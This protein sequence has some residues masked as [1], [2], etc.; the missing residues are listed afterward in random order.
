M[1]VLRFAFPALCALGVAACAYASARLIG[2]VPPGKLPLYEPWVA[3]HFASG[4]VFAVIAP[5]QFWSG[6]RARRPALHRALGRVAVAAGAAMAVSGVAVA[7]TAPARPVSEAIFMTVL[8]GGFAVFLALAVRAALARDFA[9]HRAWMARVAATGL[10]AI[11]QRLV[12]PPLAAA[13]GIDGRDTFWQ[14]FISAAWIAWA[15]NMALA[16]AWL[17]RTSPAPRPLPA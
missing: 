8:F 13:V 9:A 15:L 10:G 4:T 3:S 12:F 17:R 11:T 1:T 16:E 5:L 2:W 7:Y 14:V 6:L